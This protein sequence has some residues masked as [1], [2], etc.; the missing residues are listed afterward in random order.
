MSHPERTH[1]L[2]EGTAK[3]GFG[4]TDSRLHLEDAP[5]AFSGAM[6]VGISKMQDIHFRVSGQQ[7]LA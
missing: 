2:R 6:K 1:P 5:I 4:S 3:P 7:F